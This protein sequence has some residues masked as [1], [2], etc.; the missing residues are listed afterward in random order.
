MSLCCDGSSGHA[1]CNRTTFCR[2]HSSL[3]CSA[4]LSNAL[5]SQTPTHLSANKAHWIHLDIHCIDVDN[6]TNCELI[7][8]DGAHQ[9]QVLVQNVHQCI[10]LS[11]ALRTSPQHISEHS[12]FQQAPLVSFNA[13]LNEIGV[14][15][16]GPSPVMQLRAGRFSEVVSRNQRTYKGGGRWYDHGES[17]L[18][19]SFAFQV[20]YSGGRRTRTFAKAAWA[21]VEKQVHCQERENI[22]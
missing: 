17:D 14:G 19:K 8:R 7:N 4:F 5:K 20:S 11:R 16:M 13:R 21:S 2:S 12:R 1:S 9:R 10:R 18:A 15:V 6:T 22:Q 3:R